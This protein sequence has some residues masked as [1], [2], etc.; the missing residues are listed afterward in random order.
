MVIRKKGSAASA[1]IYVRDRQG[2]RLRSQARGSRFG[3]YQSKSK[4]RA[5]SQVRTKSDLAKDIK[6]VKK[7]MKEIK[8][9][10]DEL[11]KKRLQ[12]ET[13]NYIEEQYEMN[14]DMLM[15]LMACK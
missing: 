4:D 12:D 5:G 14:M 6:E 13:C 7:D 15:R 10:L 9:M 11:K 1:Q 2:L 3:R 8:K